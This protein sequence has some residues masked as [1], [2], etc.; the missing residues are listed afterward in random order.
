MMVPCLRAAIMATV[1][2]VVS[3]RVRRRCRRCGTN[4]SLVCRKDLFPVDLARLQPAGGGVD[5]VGA[6]E[7]GANAK[8][9]L[10]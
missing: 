4:A 8:A 2:G 7:C 5:A 6:A 1:L 10:Q 9:S 3:E